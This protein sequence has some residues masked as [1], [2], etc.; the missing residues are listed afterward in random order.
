MS[1]QTLSAEEKSAF[2]A[3]KETSNVVIRNM[4]RLKGYVV[5]KFSKGRNMIKDM[6]REKNL[7]EDKI[8][9]VSESMKNMKLED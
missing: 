7:I 8:R 4:K 9:Q 3:R 6:W 2:N 1:A 5:D